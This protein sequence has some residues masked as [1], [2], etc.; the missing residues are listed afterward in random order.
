[1]RS[2]TYLQKVNA[3][4]TT[5]KIAISIDTILT[6][7]KHFTINDSCIIALKTVFSVQKE[8]LQ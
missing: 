8:R 7:S 3:E 2:K 5:A 4:K 1:M 6:T